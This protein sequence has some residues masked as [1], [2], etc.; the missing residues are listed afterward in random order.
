[1]AVVLLAAPQARVGTLGG[2]GTEG[3]YDPDR[4]MVAYVQRISSD[5]RCRAGGGRESSN[6]DV[7][8]VK[9]CVGVAQSFGGPGKSIVLEHLSGLHAV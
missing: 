9:Q 5:P 2:G 7:I 8:E 1:M 4:A 3:E 6:E